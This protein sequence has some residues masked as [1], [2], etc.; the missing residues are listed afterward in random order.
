MQKVSCIHQQRR[1]TMTTQRKPKIK[2]V[3]VAFRGG[4]ELSKSWN[5]EVPA[6]VVK[7]W[8]ASRDAAAATVHYTADDHL[9]NWSIHVK[10]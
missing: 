10:A 3:A 5:Y 6:D 9:G 2:A 7:D 4:K 8:L 1:D